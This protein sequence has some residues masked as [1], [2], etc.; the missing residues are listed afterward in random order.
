V[1]TSQTTVVARREAETS[2]RIH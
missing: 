1:T 2:S